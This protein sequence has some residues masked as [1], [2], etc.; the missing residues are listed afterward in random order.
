[1][2]LLFSKMSELVYRNK[3]C[4]TNIVHCGGFYKFSVENSYGITMRIKV[5]ANTEKNE[6]SGIKDR[7]TMFGKNREFSGLLVY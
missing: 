5:A 6:F 7:I 2:L 4:I 3:C 1:M